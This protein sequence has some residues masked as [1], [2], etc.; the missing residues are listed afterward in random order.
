VPTAA[1]WTKYV[2]Q[3]GLFRRPPAH[4]FSIGDDRP[5]ASRVEVDA[6]SSHLG[7]VHAAAADLQNLTSPI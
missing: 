7:V 4:T 5:A 1:S 6:G 3:A 2:A